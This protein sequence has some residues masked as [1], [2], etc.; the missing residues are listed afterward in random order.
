MAL[1]AGNKATYSV[2]T[3]STV[4]DKRQGY[5]VSIYSTKTR[6]VV[7]KATANS[8]IE[9]GVFV[10]NFGTDPMGGFAKLDKPTVTGK[11][12]LGVSVFHRAFTLDWD[13]TLQAHRYKIGSLLAYA[14]EGTY[15]MYSEVPVDIGDKVWF[16]HTV[17]AGKTRIGAVANATG[18]GLDAHPTATFAEKITAPGLVAVTLP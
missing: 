12:I 5:V 15:Y 17:D 18:V 10:F 7:T 16:R 9:V 11:N 3:P 4:E 1:D 6:Q 14:S 8:A 2:F 13:N